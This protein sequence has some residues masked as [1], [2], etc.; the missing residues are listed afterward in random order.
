LGENVFIKF[1]APQN[2]NNLD[3]TPCIFLGQSIQLV[4]IYRVTQKCLLLL[5]Y[6]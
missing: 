4:K 6:L 2:S 1:K 5:G 3:G